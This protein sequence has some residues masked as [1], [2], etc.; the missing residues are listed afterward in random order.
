MAE[1]ESEPLG[2]TAYIDPS[3]QA[4]VIRGLGDIVVLPKVITSEGL[5]AGE[6]VEPVDVFLRKSLSPL[7]GPQFS[8][9]VQ[10]NDQLRASVACLE[11]QVS[12]LG[13]CVIGQHA[14]I[15]VSLNKHEDSILSELK[16]MI[17]KP[18]RID[19]VLL[20]LNFVLLW[21]VIAK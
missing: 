6:Q 19:W 3:Q 13:G 8:Y 9:L 20:F 7:V 2:I 16:N 14:E 5:N 21:L 18:R 12:A 15:Q 17:Q 11:K 4:G 1:E 10:E